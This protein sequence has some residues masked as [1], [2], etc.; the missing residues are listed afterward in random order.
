[1]FVTPLPVGLFPSNK[2][3]RQLDVSAIWRANIYGDCT[4]FSGSTSCNQ[5]ALNNEYVKQCTWTLGPF[6][7]T[8]VHLAI[9]RVF[10]LHHWSGVSGCLVH[11]NVGNDF[12]VLAMTVSIW[13]GFCMTPCVYIFR[14][15]GT[16]WSNELG[17]AKWS[18][19]FFAKVFSPFWFFSPQPVFHVW[20]PFSAFFGCL[21]ACWTEWG[22]QSSWEGKAQAWG[23]AWWDGTTCQCFFFGSLAGLKFS[24]CFLLH[25]MR[26]PAKLVGR[27]WWE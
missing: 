16:C 1:M 26:Y 5:K 8:S 12:V 17:Y 2:T 13:L 9:A 27:L 3:G 10:V 20:F 18:V 15:N 25:L 23:E 4:L 7:Y 6:S 19:C 21:C 24:S 11:Y 14:S 22:D